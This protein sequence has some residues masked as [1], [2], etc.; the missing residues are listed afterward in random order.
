MKKIFLSLIIILFLLPYSFCLDFTPDFIK[1]SDSTV[2]KDLFTLNVGIMDLKEIGKVNQINPIDRQNVSTSIKNVLESV[3]LVNLSNR[4]SIVKAINNYKAK[5]DDTGK[6]RIDFLEKKIKFS[7]ELVDRSYSYQ[8]YLEMKNNGTFTS[9]AKNWYDNYDNPIYSLFVAKPFDRTFADDKTICEI[10]KLTDSKGVARDGNIDFLFSGEMEKIDNYYFIRIYIY[11]YLQNKLIDDFSLVADSENIKEKLTEKLLE[12]IPIIFSIKYA[13]LKVNTE[14]EDASVYLNSS[15]IGKKNVEIDFIPPG[16]YV[17]IL[18]K[19]NYEDK[20]EN[21]QLSDLENKEI[22]LKIE[23]QKELQILNFNI[24]PLGTKIYINAVYEGVTPFSKAL[25]KGK[26]IVSAKNDQ[27]ENYRY[28]LTI[29]EVFSEPQNIVFQLKSKNIKSFFETKKILYYT[30]FWNFTFSLISFIPITVLSVEYY[31]LSGLIAEEETD[32]EKAIYNANITLFGLAYFFGVYT[33]VGLVWLIFSLSD[34]LITREKKDF[35][36][37]IDFQKDTK[38]SDALRLGF[39][40]RL[41]S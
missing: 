6:T 36:P 28:F 3:P 21:V 23:N 13:S 22:E 41:R 39:G 17:V 33:I 30:S 2:L 16:N 20:I 19:D 27:Y 26:Y 31:N 8:F 7:N 11:S 29:S 24:E 5:L 9:I 1:R 18:R 12:E 14:D 4:D 35:I 34:Y 15:Y 32:Y 37:I 25:P 10:T 38:G 40:I